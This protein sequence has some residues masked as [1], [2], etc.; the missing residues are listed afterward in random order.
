MI[1]ALYPAESTGGWKAPQSGISKITLGNRLATFQVTPKTPTD[2]LFRIFCRF[3]NLKKS[4]VSM[5]PGFG[6]GPKKGGIYT[7]RPFKRGD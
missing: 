7:A 5:F 4:S 2:F 1:D 3:Q 6:H